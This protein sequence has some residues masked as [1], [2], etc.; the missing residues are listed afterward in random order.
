[1]KE[2]LTSYITFSEDTYVKVTDGFIHEDLKSLR[3]AMNATDDQKK[4]L[5]KRRRKELL[6]LRRIPI[7]IAIEK[8]TWFPVRNMWTTTSIRSPRIV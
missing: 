4:M 3:K 7:T 5:K 1:M 2:T 6:G 8:N